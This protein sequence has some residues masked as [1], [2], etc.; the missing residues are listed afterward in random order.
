MSRDIEDLPD[1]VFMNGHGERNFTLGRLALDDLLQAMTGFLHAID[2]LTDVNRQP[3]R[4]ALVGNCASDRLANPPGCV[5]AELVAAVIIELVR[6]L[7]QADVA[8]LDP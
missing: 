2:G 4:P 1:L 3:D 5:R 7:H 6:R 8:F